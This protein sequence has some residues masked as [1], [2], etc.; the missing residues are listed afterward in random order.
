M[1]DITRRILAVA[2]VLGI[3]LLLA[4]CIR[5]RLDGCPL[6]VDGREITM[7]FRISTYGTVG[8]KSVVGEETGTVAENWID[9]ETVRFLLFTKGG[10]FL[11]DITA[12]A[13]E[14]K[15]LDVA[16]GTYSQ[17]IVTA[18]FKEP[19]FSAAA[20]DG[21]VEFQI[22]VLAN[23]PAPALDGISGIRSVSG[24]EELR[25]SYTMPEDFFPA[26]DPASD[27]GTGIPM[28][29]L[30]GFKVSQRQL[31]ES[32]ELD[33]VELYD[34]A[35]GDIR[36]NINMLRCLAKVEV[37]DN[38][39]DKDEDGYPCIETVSMLNRN[40]VA[41]LIPGGFENGVQVTSPSYPADPVLDSSAKAMS[42]T[43]GAFTAYIPEIS[44]KDLN[45]GNKA[46]AVVVRNSGSATD[47]TRYE[48]AIPAENNAWGA[49]LLRNHI[50]RLSV[51]L[52]SN[53]R[54]EYTVCPWDESGEI[55]IPDYPEQ[56]N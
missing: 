22:M 33:P 5:D 9:P 46:F 54:L 21:N 31:F 16:D 26:Y 4:G 39:G 24:I 13:R 40:N 11:Q 12:V 41:L 56:E 32:T 43:D 49:A 48:V 50:Y 44:F 8:T 18:T 30:K 20:V 7:T 42:E 38:I 10:G 19:Y 55:E 28:Y 34:P 3:S 51:N 17:Y 27:A 6:D 23:W 2:T 15:Q 52:S 1:A 29:G 53:I 37:I 47:V 14:Q 25:A 45:G 35:A 36:E